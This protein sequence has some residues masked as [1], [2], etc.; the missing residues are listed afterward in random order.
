MNPIGVKVKTLSLTQSRTY[1]SPMDTGFLQPQAHFVAVNTQM[2]FWFLKTHQ[3]SLDYIKHSN[4]HE[5]LETLS[6]IVFLKISIDNGLLK[7]FN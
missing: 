6:K 4:E 1:K 2:E 7:N 5:F 3:M